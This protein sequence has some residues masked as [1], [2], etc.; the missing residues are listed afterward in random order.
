MKSLRAAPHRLPL[1]RL[2]VSALLACF[3]MP[4]WAADVPI[5]GQLASQPAP[6]GKTSSEPQGHQMRRYQAFA[7]QAELPALVITGETTLEVGGA[8]KIDAARLAQLS[9][10]DQTS[11]ASR[12]AVPTGVIAKL[13][14]RISDN[15]ASG[16]S[17]F[18]GQLRT[19]VVD[20]R[21]LQGEWGRYHPPAEG[22]QTK[23]AALAALQ[24]GDI[25]QAWALYDG[26]GKPQAPA[27]GPP[28]P[29]TNLRVVAGP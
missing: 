8:L 20:Y 14:Q 2:A 29:P 5:G 6:T 7:R 4:V 15:P 26:L 12:F 19:A 9:P 28:A 23:T 10:Q 18:A 27:V 16:A 22:E 17:Q 21:F 25:A 3:L 11:L 1:W 24:V 13:V